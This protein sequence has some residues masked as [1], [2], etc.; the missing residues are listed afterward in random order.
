ME[1]LDTTIEMLSFNLKLLANKSKK[2]I[3][4][5]AGKV[6]DKQ[7]MLPAVQKLLNL[8]I[9]IYATKGTSLFFN[10]NGI[11]NIEIFKIAE[12]KEPNIMSFLKND[13]FDIVVNIL[14]GN[15]DYDEASDSNLIRKLSIENG[16]PLITD[17]DV[18]IMTIEQ[19]VERRQRS[20]SRYKI[21]DGS[22]PWNLKLEFFQLIDKLGGFA[23]Y[24]AHFDKAYLINMENLKLGHVDMKKK[25][26]LYRY[27]KENYTPEDLVQRISRALNKMIEQGV[28]YCRTFVDADKTVKLL[29]LQAALTV[30]EAY[31]GKIY[32]EIGVQPLEGV[33]NS[34]GR[35]HFFDACVKADVIGGLP[36]RDRPRMENHLDIIM[37]MAKDLNK[38]LDVHVDQENNPYED[39]TELLAK[40]TIQYGL[41]GRVSA[42]HAISVAA[43][44]EMEM[45]R[46]IGLIKD[47]GLNIIVCPSAAL[48]MKPLS[49]I[50]APIHNSIAPVVR[51]IEAGIP[52]YIGTDNIN[53][54]F[55]PVS[56]GD[57]WF[58]CRLLMEACRYYDVEKIAQIATDKRGFTAI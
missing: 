34:E 22:E 45:N 48:S 1:K 54:L 9:V 27:L 4:I 52:V 19:M 15:N 30:K 18:A 12:T 5:S 40:K 47:A 53:D 23:C 36:S 28:T 35:K 39:E 29:P 33:L 51:F 50:N 38:R 26:E 16:I 20:I 10:E 43:K 41:E 25:W 21:V 44:P 6:S 2:N 57:M 3:L 37:R 49:N 42:V 58:E 55:M 46:I 7:K 13:R 11:P 31:K 32:F 8:N 24:H 14:T 17:V 56:D